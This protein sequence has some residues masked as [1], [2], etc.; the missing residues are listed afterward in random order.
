MIICGLVLYGV[1]F[2]N[3]FIQERH[4][5]KIWKFIPTTFRY[6]WIDDVIKTIPSLKDVTIKSPLSYINDRTKDHL[7][8]K[9]DI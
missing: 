3:E 8:W 5:M 4:R 6:W 2:A 9:D 7:R 1:C